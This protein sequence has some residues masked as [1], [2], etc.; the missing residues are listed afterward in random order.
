[1]GFTVLLAILCT[2]GQYALASEQQDIEMKKLSAESGCNLCHSP[3]HRK[4][5][6]NE[7]LPIGPAWEDVARK[8]RGQKGAV[9]RLVRIVLQGSGS[10]DRHWSGR[11]SGVTMLPNAVEISKPDAE[12]LVRWILSLDKTAHQ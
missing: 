5:G 3:E 12:K 8:Y 4:Y 11:A 9:D 10:Q 1:M 6:S 2:S 7:L